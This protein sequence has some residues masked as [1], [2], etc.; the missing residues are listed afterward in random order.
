M[1]RGRLC[2]PRIWTD[3]PSSAGASGFVSTA[4]VVFAPSLDCSVFTDLGATWYEPTRRLGLRL[5]AS[6]LVS[7]ASVGLAS[8]VS[9]PRFGSG[10]QRPAQP[11]LD[12]ALIV[13]PCAR[14][15][16]ARRT[17]Q[18][19]IRRSRRSRGRRPGSTVEPDRKFARHADAAMRRPMA[20][21]FTLVERDTGPGDALHVRHRRVA[22]DIGA[23]E[24][25]FWMTSNTPNGV[26]RLGTPVATDVSATWVPSL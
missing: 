7:T 1:A 23:V 24:D 3:Q 6:S 18:V 8:A 10:P 12:P 25:R 15:D 9:R 20:D 19:S 4:S 21:I 11:R 13:R 14:T 22:V 16:A 26:G 17:P 5:G 2:E